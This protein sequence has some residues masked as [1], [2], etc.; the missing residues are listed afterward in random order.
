MKSVTATKHAFP[1]DESCCEPPLFDWADLVW[2]AIIALF[3]WGLIG[4]MR[5][6][7]G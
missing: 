3:I 4:W 7:H 1:H 5:S 2:V 6:L